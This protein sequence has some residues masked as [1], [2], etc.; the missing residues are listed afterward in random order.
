VA[1]AE[2]LALRARAAARS[3]IS[4]GAAALALAVPFLFLHIKYEPGVR[5]PLGSTHLGLELSDLAVV[6]VGLFALREGLRT[7][8]APLR[9][10][11]PLLIA[12]AALAVW[13][14]VRSES[15]E[16]VVTATKFAE[17]GLLALSAPLI[18]RR[19]EDWELVASVVVAWSVAATCFGLLQIFGVDMA[20]AWAAGRRQPSFLGHSDFAALSVFA[21]GIGLAAV[22]LAGR[23][24]GWIAI[25]TG[26][27]GLILAGATAGLIGTGLGA[28]GLLYAISR[29]RRVAVRDVALSG[30]I[31]LVVSAGVLVLRAGDFEHFLRFLH[32]KGRETQTADIQTYSHHTLLAYI[33]YR[34][35]RDH[36]VAGAGWQASTEPETVDP[37]LPAAHRKFPDVSP[38]AFP[39]RVHEWGV[40][41][42]YVQAAADL[43]VIGLLLWLAPFALALL[44]AVR[45]NAPPGAVAVFV[46]LGAMG[47]W[48]GQGLV[49]GIPLDAVTWLGFGLAATA[50]TQRSRASGQRK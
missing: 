28:A 46:I 32:V 49:A 20:D 26:S 1:V 25:G 44:L 7:D 50:A 18:L 37:Q 35:W 34:I 29:R 48:A 22:L 17:Y 33:G 31:V 40:Q 9:P 47:V 3:G 39:T 23:R 12:A 10:A 2:T 8:F 27:L 21:L 16:H 13:I 14:L 30:A 19:R 43:G 41:N 38:L 24:I 42:A 11:L 5:V 15:L 45:A 36:P 4:P 6:V